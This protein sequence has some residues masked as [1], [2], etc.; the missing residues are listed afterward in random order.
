MRNRVAVSLTAVAAVAVLLAGSFGTYG[1]MK[2]KADVGAVVVHTVRLR[3]CAR[4]RA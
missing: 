1:L 2:K 4:S 3:T